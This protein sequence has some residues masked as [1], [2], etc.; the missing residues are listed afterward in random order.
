[1]ESRHSRVCEPPR[2]YSIE[3]RQNQWKLNGIAPE[4]METQ[5]NRARINGNSMESRQNQWKLNGIVCLNR[6][7]RVCLNSRNNARNAVRV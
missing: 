4:S 2:L 1:M 5:R 7:I 3:S 6:D